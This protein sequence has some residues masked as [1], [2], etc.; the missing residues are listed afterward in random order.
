MS[1]PKQE[2]REEN[3]EKSQVIRKVIH[4]LLLVFIASLTCS[5]LQMRCR[6]GNTSVIIDCLERT[7]LK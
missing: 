3:E 4:H 6:I 7:L 1:K 5:N 2:G